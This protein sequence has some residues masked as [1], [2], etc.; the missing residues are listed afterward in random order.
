MRAEFREEEKVSF[1]KIGRPPKPQKLELVH[2]D[3]W[4]PSLVQSIEGSRYYISFIDNS[5][6]KV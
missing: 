2:M 1:L 5:S 3:L 4:G 6:R